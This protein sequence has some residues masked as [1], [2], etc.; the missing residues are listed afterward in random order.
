MK[1]GLYVHIPFCK[2]KCR[3]CDFNSY[4]KAEQY[5]SPYFSAVLKEA[6]HYSAT[7]SGL[8]TVYFGGGTPTSI[9]PKLLGQTLD[10]FFDVF[11]ISEDAEITAEC[12]PGTIGFDGLKVL[13][14]SGINRL[15]I[16][17]QTT[18]DKELKCLGRIHTF[19]DFKRC[20]EN[21]RSAGFENISLD[22][23]YG[24]PDQSL[25]DWSRTLDT[26]ASFGAEH[27]SCY[28]L[29]VEE[30]TPFAEADL[31]LP[32][33][34]LAAD[35][36]ELAVKRLAKYGCA[37]YEISNFAKPG[38]ESRHNIKYWR[39]DDFLGLGAGAY[40]C[41]FGRRFSNVCK[42]DEYI[43]SVSETGLAEV[44]SAVQN[45]KE[46]MSEFMFLGLRLCKGVKD[47]E[48][49]AR[50]GCSF[51]DVF[52]EAVKKYTDWGFLVSDGDSL[53]LSD[54][55]FFVSNTILADFV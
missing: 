4:A 42:I 46:Q 19:D 53:R 3:Y 51:T 39:C 15:S 23:M 50:F 49:M 11:G 28:L 48:F 6:Q 2:S 20:F 7:V 1:T 25:E 26:A 38:K 5:I 54:K 45:K 40:S 27:I 24:L 33:D 18:D 55:G 47:S 41:L 13:R 52:S 32:D 8:D 12:N 31:K 37:R 30:G 35:M 43:S 10:V 9:E 14:Q 29:K 34:D 36:Y 22:L 21:A 17:L 44:W 16:G